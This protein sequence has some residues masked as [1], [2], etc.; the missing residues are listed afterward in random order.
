MPKVTSQLNFSVQIFKHVCCR[1]L[2]AGLSV[3]AVIGIVMV[4]GACS[5]SKAWS[6]LFACNTFFTKIIDNVLFAFVFCLFG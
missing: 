3:F 2:F 6:P 5:V 4:I 1:S